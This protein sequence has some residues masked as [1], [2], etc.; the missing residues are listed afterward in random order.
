M[1]DYNDTLVGPYLAGSIA[2]LASLVWRVEHRGGNWN[3]LMSGPTSSLRIVVAKGA[4]VAWLAAAMQAVLAVA[5]IPAAVAQSALS[6][7]LRSF[8]APIAVALAGAAVSTAAL[9]AAGSVGLISPTAWRPARPCSGRGSWW[10][11]AKWRAWYRLD[12]GGERAA[13][14]RP[15]RRYRLASRPTRHPHLT[16]QKGD[17]QRVTETVPLWPQ[18]AMHSNSVKRASDADRLGDHGFKV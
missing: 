16:D 4:T 14:Y 9:M 7:F 12:R 8:A 17:N 3:A 18:E 5:C 15:R 13:D 10:T 1:W 11:P 6:L 2:I